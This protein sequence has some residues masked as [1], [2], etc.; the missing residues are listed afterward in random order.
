MHRHIVYPGSIPLDT[1]FLSAVKDSY[2]GAGWLAESAIGVNT[3]VVGLAVT[4]TSP[5]SLQVNVAP[6]AI[7]SLQTVDSAAYGA[8]G[9]DANQFTKQGILAAGTTLTITPP[10]T[11]GQSINYL[12]QVAFAET[13]GNPIILPYYNASNPSVAWSGP[14]NT[15]VA[16]NTVRSDTCVVG[17][18]AGAP[19]ATGSQVTPAPDVGYTGVYVVTV[20]QG[21][22]TI[23]GG[24][25]ALL[26]TAPYFPTLPQIPPTA[27]SGVWTYAIAGGTANA[28][29][30]TLSPAPSALTAGMA[31]R[32][33][34]SA[35]NSGTATLNVN[36]LGPSPIVRSDLSPLLISDL[37]ANTTA[38]LIYNGTSWQII[39]LLNTTK[40][41]YQGVASAG[42]TLTVDQIGAVVQF[43]VGSGPF[44]VNLPQSSSC[45]NGGR[46]NFFHNGNNP[47]TLQVQGGDQIGYADGT[48][49][50]SIV[51]NTGDT[52]ELLCLGST[53]TWLIIDG[54]MGNRAASDFKKN[55]SANGYQKI[56]GGLIVQWGTAIGSTG[57]TVTVNFP[58]AFTSACYAVAATP[59][60][61][62][63]SAINCL[64][65]AINVNNFGLTTSFGGSFSA[66]TAH[67]IAIGR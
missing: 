57:G 21:Q 38:E 3:Q 5:A 46:I 14:N 36:G 15:G 58:I 1:D 52:L 39:G 26:P 6:G 44:T 11:V 9:T 61:A 18:K 17:L 32:L 40:P 42:G 34:I 31:I 10:G 54:S 8:L 56:P 50:A 66:L 51:V 64:T 62:T 45:P 4:P 53:G 29:T 47:V 7:Y 65:S 67:Y 12:V 22:T 23:T 33:K 37:T 60:G 16:Q 25:I 41:F 19:A 27:Q 59:E 13:D 2:Y 43:G 28:L 63:V 49:S 30:A 55:L 48:L 24:N 20:A 35:T